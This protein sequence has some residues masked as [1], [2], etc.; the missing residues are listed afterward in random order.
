[1]ATKLPKQLYV[2]FQ[3][4]RDP[5]KHPL[6]FLNAYDPGKASFEKKR[7]TQD[8]WA[9]AQYG[10]QDPRLVMQPNG[11]YFL[12]Y[13]KVTGYD[14]TKH[15]N[16]PG[17]YITETIQEGITAQPEIWNNDALP[18]FMILNSVSRWSTSN[19]VWRILDPRGIE[20]EIPTSKMDEIIELAGIK[21]GGEI[22]AKCCWAGNKNLVLL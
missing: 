12:E 7:L 19:K 15:Y 8:K 16:E 6:G 17:Y 4:V 21:K 10:K 22:D 9:Y 3:G 14:H 1:M 2:T 5:N 20:F 11:L 18:G 13:Q